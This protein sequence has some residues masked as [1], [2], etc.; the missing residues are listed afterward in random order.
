VG[1]D[2]Q[3]IAVGAQAGILLADDDHPREADRVLS[4]H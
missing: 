2:D 1:D 4:L 3:V